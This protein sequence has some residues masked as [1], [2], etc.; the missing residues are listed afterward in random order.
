MQEIARARAIKSPVDETVGYCLL[1]LSLSCMTVGQKTCRI[2]IVICNSCFVE[3]GVPLTFM[4]GSLF[5]F[6]SRAK[7]VITTRP[8]TSNNAERARAR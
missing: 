1:V 7:S 4:T 5:R 8:F 2:A 6:K 3:Y